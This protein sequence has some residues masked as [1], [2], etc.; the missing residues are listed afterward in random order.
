MEFYLNQQ[1]MQQTLTPLQSKIFD[2]KISTLSSD[3]SGNSQAMEKFVELYGQFLTA[4]AA[5]R[6]ILMKDILLVNDAIDA[7]A[8]MDTNN[9][10]LF[11]IGGFNNSAFSP[12]GFNTNGTFSNPFA[13]IGGIK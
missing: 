11:N 1:N 10:G 3:I 7:F 2:I 9:A 5:Y 4:L 6:E 12:N 8:M 13:P